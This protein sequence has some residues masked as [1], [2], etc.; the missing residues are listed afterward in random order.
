[1]RCMVPHLMHM[2]V[3]NIQEELYCEL[4]DCHQT[5]LRLD[6]CYRDEAT[7]VPE[8]AFMKCPGKI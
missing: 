5:L 7:T 8:T 1:M 6:F 4:I 3:E 2:F